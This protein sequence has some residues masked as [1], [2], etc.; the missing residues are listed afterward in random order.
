MS[1]FDGILLIIIITIITTTM[2]ILMLVAEG[3]IDQDI[4]RDGGGREIVAGRVW[5]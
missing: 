3:D 5:W 1:V 4:A 2:I